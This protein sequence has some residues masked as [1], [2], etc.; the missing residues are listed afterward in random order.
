MRR[1]LFGLAL[2]ACGPAW[3]GD[4]V[5]TKHVTARLVADVASVRAR[6][7]ARVGLQLTIIPGWHTHWR[8]PGDAGAP[9]ALAWTLSEGATVGPLAFPT[10][11]PLAEGPLMTYAHTGT[12]LLVAPLTVAHPPAALRLHADW[13]VCQEVCVPEQ[14]DFAL[15]LPADDGAASPNAPL[16]RAAAE[17]L[18]R[19]APGSA[20]VT[21]DDVLTL[22]DPAL[23]PASVKAA[24]F[25]PDTPDTLND[26]AP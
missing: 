17:A 1:L 22:R 3:A 20:T 8:N 7:T 19:P 24:R 10:P 25:V 5:T 13:L 14:G 26:A 16:F 2:L 6:Q 21:P 12:P 11:T 18:P 9:P 15:D 23:T 4:T